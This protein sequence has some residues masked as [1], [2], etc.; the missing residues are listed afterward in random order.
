MTGDQINTIKQVLKFEKK[1]SRNQY[2]GGGDK[3][4]IIKEGLI[5]IMI[6]APHSINQYRDG[7]LKWADRMTGGIALFLQKLTGCHLIYSARYSETDANYDSN[8][9]NN[10]Q[11]QT[12][13]VEYIKTHNIQVLI[14][15]HGASVNRE[16]AIEIGTA[17]LRD[18]NDNIIGNEFR[19]LQGRD[20]L[21]NLVKYTFDFYFR[22]LTFSKKEIWHNKIFDAGRQN[23]ITK[24]VSEN[25]NCSCFQLEINGGFRDV[26]NKSELLQLIQGLSYLIKTLNNID[27]TASNIN[28]YRLWQSNKHRPQDKI[29]L[30]FPERKTTIFE[31]FSLLHICSCLGGSELVRLHKV[32]DNTIY[33]FRNALSGNNTT[34]NEEEYIFLTNRLIENLYGRDWILT[35]ERL[36]PLRG[37]PVVVWDSNKDIYKIGYPKA[38]NIES[39][40]LSSLLYQS[41]SEDAYKFEFVVF[42]RYT[43]SRIYIDFL[44]SDYRDYGRVKDGSGNPAMKVMLPRYYRRLLGYLD[45]PF[46]TMRYEEF[47]NL[48]QNI[49]KEIDNF[50]TQVYFIQGDCYVLSNDVLDKHRFFGLFKTLSLDTSVLAS[51]LTEAER[52]DL[53]S[54]LKREFTEPLKCCYEKIQGEVFCKLKEE[55]LTNDAHSKHLYK[56]TEIQRYFGLYDVVEILHEPR[57]NNVKI[58]LHRKICCFADKSIAQIMNKIVGKIECSLKTTYTSETDDKNN[59]ARL[60][61]NMM[62]LIG[63][64]END[65]IVIKFGNRKEVLRVLKDQLLTDFQIGIPA[66]SRKRLGM[67]SINDIVVVSRDMLHIFKR[68]SLEQTFAI[69]GLIITITQMTNVLYIG[70][71]FC[72]IFIPLIIY[73]ILNDERIKV[74]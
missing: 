64:S 19:S 31:E 72:I 71:I 10:N 44:R 8:Q 55:V 36:S 35:E 53:I 47:R 43:D 5:P 57:T 30:L 41:K 62:S 17:P 37:I 38:D 50:I 3:N 33:S 42:N 51:N 48:I 60:S 34:I 18:S 2:N 59:V 23:T 21:L 13:L 20:F 69:I 7:K 66:P 22:E 74:Q 61:P 52:Q 67:N 70:I 58:P 56:T 14:D 15:L 49:E 46:Y 16:Y 27:W 45:Y 32:N 24:Y 26:N 1:F 40:C 28:V 54:L 63:V 6:S 25:S 4:F 65:K 11:Y 12:N 39:I 29:E 68:H 9:N 73:F